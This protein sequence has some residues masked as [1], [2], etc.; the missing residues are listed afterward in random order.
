M[1]I[2]DDFKMIQIHIYCYYIFNIFYSRLHKTQCIGYYS[3]RH[4]C[5]IQAI[6][7]D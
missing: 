6:P 2:S 3:P 7:G 1:Y 4:S 5:V